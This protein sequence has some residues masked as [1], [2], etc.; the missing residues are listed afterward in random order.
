MASAVKGHVDLIED[1][2]NGLLFPYGD[3]RRCAEQILKLA[4]DP[5]LC[6]DLT[7]NA[8][9]SLDQYSLDAVLPQI[10]SYYTMNQ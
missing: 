6:K 2:K 9:Q 1:N 3:S 10:M 5:R 4:G 8:G 7:E